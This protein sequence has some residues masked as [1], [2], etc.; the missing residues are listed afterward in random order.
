MASD[1]TAVP[2]SERE[3]S[4]KDRFSRVWHED[5][6][7]VFADVASYYDKANNVATLG[8]CGW[9]RRS[10]LSMIDL[11]P[12]QKVLDVCAGTNAVGIGMLNREPDLQVSAIDRSSAM[13]EE[14]AR[15]A[16]RQGFTIESTIGDVHELP[17]PD[18]TF[19]VVTLQF[20][21]RHLRVIEVFAEIHRVL[22]PGGAFYHS[23]M[24][25]PRT[26]LME[27]IHYLYLRFCLLFTSWLFNSGATAR[28][29]RSYF[30]HAL[31]DFY[32]AAELTELLRGMGFQEV[33]SRTLMG[34]LLGFHK[35]R[36]P[37][38]EEDR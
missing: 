26:R 16:Q 34:G 37:P 25:R 11:E 4:R 1:M 30:I 14:G 20:A 7:E 36:K 2:F 23:D 10:L 17:F 22:K 5:L 8:L 6:E 24:L 27:E 3:A 31:R 13:Q 18:N 28:G 35:A 12:G 15:R 19:D 21:S 33:E 38:P 32:S 9:F 29:C